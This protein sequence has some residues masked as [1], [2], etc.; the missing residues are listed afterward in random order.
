MWPNLQSP[1]DLFSFTAEILHEKPFFVQWQ[2]SQQLRATLSNF[3]LKNN[4]NVVG[5]QQIKKRK[6]AGQFLKKMILQ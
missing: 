5:K 4:L 1:A 2:I 6:I 3:L